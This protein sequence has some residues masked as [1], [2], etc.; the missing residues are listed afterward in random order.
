MSPDETI[1]EIKREHFDRFLEAKDC[2]VLA[3]LL[4]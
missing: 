1:S 4:K 2:A 3:K